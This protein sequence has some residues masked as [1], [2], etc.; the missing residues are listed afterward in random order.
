MIRQLVNYASV[1]LV[2]WHVSCDS[3][4]WQFKE[5]VFNGVFN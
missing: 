5:T 2:W 3:V 4:I 1:R